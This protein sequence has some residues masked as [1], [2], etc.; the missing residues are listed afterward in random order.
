M[1][2]LS[3]KRLSLCAALAAACA[4]TPAGAVTFDFENANQPSYSSLT[5]TISGLTVTVSTT[6]P[7]YVLAQDVGVPLLGKVALIGSVTPAANYA[8]FV[9]LKFAFSTA[10]SSITFAFGDAGGDPDPVLVQAYDA[11]NN[12]LGSVTASYD[13]GVSTGSTVTAAFAGATSYIVSSG[14]SPAYNNPNSLGWEIKDAV[15]GSTS[16]AVPEPASWALFISGFGL[17]A[18][19]MRRRARSG[20]AAPALIA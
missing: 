15:V 18:G 10:L 6:T 4:I 19:S 1:K 13:E 12:L 9:P 7:G 5:Q 8:Q 20:I 16:T 3:L 2:F 14:T 17:L 11:L